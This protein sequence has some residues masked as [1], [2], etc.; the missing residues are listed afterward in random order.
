MPGG[1]VSPCASYAVE[2][3]F[4]GLFLGSAWTLVF[5]KDVFA[6]AKNVTDGSPLSASLSRENTKDFD[7]LKNVSEQ[8]KRGARTIEKQVKV[9][10]SRTWL[11]NFSTF[12]MYLSVSRSMACSLERIRGKSDMFNEFC[13]GFCGGLTFSLQSLGRGAPLSNAARAST[14]GKLALGCGCLHAFLQPTVSILV[15]RIHDILCIPYH[16]KHHCSSLV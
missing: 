5:Q 4:Q 13:G 10:L 16:Q 8:A 6:Y 12:A 7:Q 1:Y 11:R 3:V 2:S 14:A 9:G 15:A